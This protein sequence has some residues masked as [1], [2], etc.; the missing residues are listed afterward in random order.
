M[1]LPRLLATVLGARTREPDARRVFAASR[2][3]SRYGDAP[4]HGEVRLPNTTIRDVADRLKQGPLDPLCDSSAACR[5]EF[6]Q[7]GRA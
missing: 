6:R 1:K 2:R 5:E 7:T 3:R 4:Y